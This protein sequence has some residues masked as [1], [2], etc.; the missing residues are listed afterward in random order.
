MHGCSLTA[1][2]KAI[3]TKRITTLPLAA[4]ASAVERNVSKSVADAGLRDDATLYSRSRSSRDAAAARHPGLAV[5]RQEARAHGRCV[6]VTWVVSLDDESGVWPNPWPSIRASFCSPSMKS[7]MAN[8]SSEERTSSGCCHSGALPRRCQRDGKAKS[9]TSTVQR[10]ANGNGTITEFV[11]LDGSR[12]HTT[13]DELDRFV[14]GFSGS[15][16]SS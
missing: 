7:Y 8:P 11:T 14:A 2:Q 5:G 9:E 15:T 13:D 6:R 1:V 4:E 10:F 12:C 3:P 16:R